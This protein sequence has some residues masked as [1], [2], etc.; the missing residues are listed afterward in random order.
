MKKRGRKSWS[1]MY[2]FV[3]YCWLLLVMPGLSEELEEL[4]TAPPPLPW[5]MQGSRLIHWLPSHTGQDWPHQCWHPW[6]SR[7][8]MLVPPDSCLC[9]RQHCP[10]QGEILA[11]GHNEASCCQVIPVRSWSEPAAEAGTRG[12]A[13][14][15]SNTQEGSHT[16]PL[17]I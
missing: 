3:G 17:G 10:E 15:I 14:K 8:H 5:R 9:P 4:R 12:G 6:A 16:L 11:V 2:S 13:E 1:R 7:L